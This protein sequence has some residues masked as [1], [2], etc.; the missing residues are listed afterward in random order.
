MKNYKE[1]DSCH[2]CKFLFVRREYDDADELYCTKNAP[3]RPECMSVSMNECPG[4]EGNMSIYT[5]ADKKWD[6]WK[7]DREVKA[8][9]VCD[10][11]IKER[12][13]F[14]TNL[15]NLTEVKLQIDKF[16]T[17]IKDYGYEIAISKDYKIVTMHNETHGGDSELQS[18]EA[19]L[20]Y[21]N[22]FANSLTM[23][24]NWVSTEKQLP[25][26][27][28]AIIANFGDNC[29]RVLQLT[30]HYKYK[31]K[32]LFFCVAGGD[33]YPLEDVKEWRYL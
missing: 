7:E 5:K 1:Y 18:I 13:S 16:I 9:G 28:R 8:Y 20:F 31:T 15:K 22:G 2:N 33:Y 24:Y 6:E 17:T 27:D 21:L 32:K 19:M 12:E 23:S 14:I 4:L 3:T 11:F 29:L 30:T 25:E 26:L 10:D